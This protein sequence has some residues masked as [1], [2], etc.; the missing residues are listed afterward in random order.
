M[1]IY[2]YD[3][4]NIGENYGSGGNTQIND[5]LNQSIQQTDPAKEN[6]LANQADA[7]IW[8][9]A[10]W[11]PLYQRP[12]IF[13]VNNTLVNLGAPGFADY[14]YQDIGFKS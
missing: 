1:G 11:L 14:R 13:G 12:Q 6:A 7:L 3:P 2:R 5:L 10:A 4:A 9:N 8:Q